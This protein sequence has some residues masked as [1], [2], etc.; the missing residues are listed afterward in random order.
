MSQQIQYQAFLVK[1][2]GTKAFLNTML[3][4]E[5]VPLFRARFSYVLTI[6]MSIFDITPTPKEVS[7]GFFFAAHP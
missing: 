3:K 6:F 5:D 4:I 7:L 1:C 2:H